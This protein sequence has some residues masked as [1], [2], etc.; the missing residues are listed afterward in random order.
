LQAVP[1]IWRRSRDM[2][3]I[4]ACGADAAHSLNKFAFGLFMQL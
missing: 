3:M 1:A 2:L 4:M